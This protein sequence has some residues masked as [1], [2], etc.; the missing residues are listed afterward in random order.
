MKMRNKVTQIKFLQTI[1]E[2]KMKKIKHFG[3]IH[4]E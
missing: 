2:I 4:N 3:L 1:L